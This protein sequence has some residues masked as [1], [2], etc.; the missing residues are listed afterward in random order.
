MA[1][2]VHTLQ[3]RHNKIS[4]FVTK[5]QFQVLIYFLLLM[6]R[7]LFWRNRIVLNQLFN[8]NSYGM[9]NNRIFV[10]EIFRVIC[11]IFHIYFP[12]CCK[13]DGCVLFKII[14]SSY[15]WISAQFEQERMI[16]CLVNSKSICA[17]QT[18]IQF[19]PFFLFWLTG[20]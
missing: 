15:I 13:Y 16:V 6:P 4:L 5:E 19:E 17:I 2:E 18:P 14:Q 8:F 9:Q 12:Y 1:D 20:G 10:T 7:I 11:M 3:V